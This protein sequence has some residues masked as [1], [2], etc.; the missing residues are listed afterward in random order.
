MNQ[1]LL[2]KNVTYAGNLTEHDLIKLYQNAKLHVLC[3]F[4]ET[5]GLSSLEAGF[6]GCNI[7]STS[8]GS[9]EE[10]FKNM[11][12]YCNPYDDESVYNA[13]KGGLSFDQQP[14]LRQYILENFNSEK[15]LR[16]LY[17][18]YFNLI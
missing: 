4:V 13:V 11:A 17:D 5:P 10:Y 6:L 3:S 9:T 18:S 1:C 14:A 16:P 2:L 15:C 8:E 12:L 7:V